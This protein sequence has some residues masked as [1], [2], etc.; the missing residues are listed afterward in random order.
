VCSGGIKAVINLFKVCPS[1]LALSHAHTH[2]LSLSASI[3]LSL[4]HTHIHTYTYTY[5]HT[6]THTHHHHHQELSFEEE[7]LTKIVRLFKDL[8]AHKPNVSHMI[9][10]IHE[11]HSVVGLLVK[12]L[13]DQTQGD[14]VC[15]C[16]CVCV[17]CVCV[18][19]RVR[20]CDVCDAVCVL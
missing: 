15:V 2:T 7:L 19:V 8:S 18:C 11:K 13:S 1:V 6:N 14:Q 3:S 16:V 10:D 4:T 5:T 17:M 20:V 12:A 9:L